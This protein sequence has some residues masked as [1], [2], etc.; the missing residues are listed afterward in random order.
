VGSCWPLA[1]ICGGQRAGLSLLHSSA[2]LSFSQLRHGSWHRFSRSGVRPDVPTE[3]LAA[4]GWPYTFYH[5]HGAAKDR[6]VQLPERTQFTTSVR[7]RAGLGCGDADGWDALANEWGRAGGLSGPCTGA[8]PTAR[9]FPRAQGDV[10]PSRSCGSFGVIPA[11]GTGI[12]GGA[13]IL[14]TGPTRALLLR[15]SGIANP[16]WL[17]SLHAGARQ[18]LGASWINIPRKRVGAPLRAGARQ[19]PPQLF[20]LCCTGWDTPT[21]PNRVACRR[22]LGWAPHPHDCSAA[23]L[24]LRRADDRWV[25]AGAARYAHRGWS[26]R[27][28]Q[29]DLRICSA[30]FLMFPCHAFEA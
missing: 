17:W 25:P 14:A 29:C 30:A 8:P 28:Q 11:G 20:P 4:V 2:S 13:G 7:L 19:P 22:G 18:P 16:D 9:F 21:G 15:Q 5:R 26:T 1:S 6:G 24:R 12:R 3:R 23:A 27:R 10:S